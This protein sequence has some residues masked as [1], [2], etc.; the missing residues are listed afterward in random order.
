ML[1]EDFKQH[2]TKGDRFE[3]DDSL[4]EEEQKQKME[5]ERPLNIETEFDEFPKDIL[6]VPSTIKKQAQSE[7]PIRKD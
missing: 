4:Y 5:T 2:I 6:P 1:F 3:S 7:M